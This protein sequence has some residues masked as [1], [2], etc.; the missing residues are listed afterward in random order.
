MTTL[1]TEVSSCYRASFE[2]SPAGICWLRYPSSSYCSSSN[3]LAQN[4]FSIWAFHR[5][6]V[7]GPPGLICRLSKEKAAP[8]IWKWK[9]QLMV[10]VPEPSNNFKWLVLS[11]PTLRTSTLLQR[12]K[13]NHLREA[14]TEIW[15]FYIK[16]SAARQSSL[17][18]SS[19][20]LSLAVTC[21]RDLKFL[22]FWNL[23]VSSAVQ[24]EWGTCI[25]MIQLTDTVKHEIFICPKRAWNITVAAD[26]PGSAQFLCCT[27]C[28]LCQPVISL[29]QS[30]HSVSG[31][32]TW[33]PAY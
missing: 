31:V 12:E 20:R 21:G 10:T 15:H 3:L 6:E 29:L 16:R 24:N 23:K 1:L 17:T 11:E 30:C 19:F 4:T 9:L 18:D 14:G 22:S 7:R 28:H 13:K 26:L 25:L 8:D 5:S 33:V 32:N 2:L 27:L